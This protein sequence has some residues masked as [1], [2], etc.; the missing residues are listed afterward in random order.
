[1]GCK[2]Q[3]ACFLYFRH[4]LKKDIELSMCCGSD[5]EPKLPSGEVCDVYEAIEKT[6]ELHKEKEKALEGLVRVMTTK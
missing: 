2:Y 3:G 6:T 4:A 5:P 1:M